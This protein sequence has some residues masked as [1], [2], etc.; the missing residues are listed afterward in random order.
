MVFLTAVT[1]LR[2]RGPD[3]WWR[4]RKIF[5]LAAVSF[6]TFELQDSSQIIAKC[7]KILIFLFSFSMADGEIATQLPSDQC[8]A[9]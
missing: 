6:L 1:L 2:N 5:K 3:A 8:I 9:L 4:K 7:F